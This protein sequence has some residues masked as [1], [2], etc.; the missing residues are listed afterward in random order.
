[1]T[2]KNN[3]FKYSEY[4]IVGVD[5]KNGEPLYNGTPSLFAALMQLYPG[6][7]T[8]KAAKQ[9][10]IFAEAT[11]ELSQEPLQLS[12]VKLDEMFAPKRFLYQCN[13]NSDGS[14]WIRIIDEKTG[15]V[16][17]DIDEEIVVDLEKRFG[18]PSSLS[19]SLGLRSYLVN[20][21]EILPK[22]SLTRTI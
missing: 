19:F 14:I 4:I 22:D 15:S 11:M 6:F 8:M 10:Q 20:T 18:D 9:M 3:K 1:M 13:H 5:E 12:K 2:T 21:G 16:Q 17:V 7:K